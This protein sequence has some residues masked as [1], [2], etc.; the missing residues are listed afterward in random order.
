MKFR[1]TLA[2]LVLA[3]LAATAGLPRDASA[4]PTTGMDAVSAVQPL[5]QVDHVLAQGP[6]ADVVAAALVN[7][8]V[9]PAHAP[10]PPE[11]PHSSSPAS[12]G[13][14]ALGARQGVALGAVVSGGTMRLGKLKRYAKQLA[15]LTYRTTYTA[16]G[17]RHFCVWRMWM[18]QC[19]QVDD[20]V[21]AA[22]A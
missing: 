22:A 1:S 15:P 19:F 17:E 2:P 4:R 12:V 6:A 20:V 16:D 3:L 18:G 10:V 7:Q 11:T 14:D 9:Q 13:S 21:M 8:E 5:H